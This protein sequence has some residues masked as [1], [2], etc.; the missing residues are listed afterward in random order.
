MNTNLIHNILNVAIAVIAVLS[1][2]EVVALMPP[3]VA[4]A[5]V[6]VLATAKSVINVVRDGFG[7][8]VKS[9]PSVK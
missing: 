9:Q 8:L 7:G 2:P 1:L 3:S 6:G 4:L 5:L